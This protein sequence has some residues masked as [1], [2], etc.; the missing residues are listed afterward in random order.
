MPTT[1]DVAGAR[2]AGYS[3]DEILQHL[4]Q[5]GKFDVAG[6][7]KSGY[8]PQEILGHFQQKQIGDQ[9]NAAIAG[10]TR[11]APPSELA[12]PFASSDPV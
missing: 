12:R 10:V 11:P 6:A 4:G 9:A 7:M 8:Q 2:Q 3:D 1:F 5:T